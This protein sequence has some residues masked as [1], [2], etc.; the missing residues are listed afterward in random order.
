MRPSALRSGPFGDFVATHDVSVLPR[1]HQEVSKDNG[2]AE[3]PTLAPVFCCRRVGLA[4]V[5]GVCVRGPALLSAVLCSGE[6]GTEIILA[7]CA[8]CAAAP[9][10]VIV[11]GHA[12][13][14][15]YLGRCLRGVA[16]LAAVLGG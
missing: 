14:A 9:V 3:Q 12:G 15:V 10:A 7:R 1:Y 5:A 6:A 2:R 13:S 8:R 16:V 4:V 11:G